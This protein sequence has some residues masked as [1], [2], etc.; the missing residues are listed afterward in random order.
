MGRPHQ[1]FLTGDQI[2]ADDCDDELL[3][4]LTDAGDVLL[5]WSNKGETFTSSDPTSNDTTTYSASDL[6]PSTR[7][8]VITNAGFT[9]DDRR[10]HL[11]SLGEFFAMYL[12]AWSDV[13]WSDPLTYDEFE[14]ITE[15]TLTEHPDFTVFDDVKSGIRR[16]PKG[17]SKVSRNVARGAPSARERPNL[18]DPRRS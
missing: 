6:A 12:F 3:A 14:A 8:D 18:H 13:L 11:I 5:G 9:G 1:L 16:P 7:W 4:S 17:R 15:V 2:Y 10:S